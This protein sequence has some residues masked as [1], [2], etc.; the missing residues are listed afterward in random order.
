[1]KTIFFLSCILLSGIGFVYAQPITV[2]GKV[3]VSSGFAIPNVT[4]KA[5]QEKRVIYSDTAGEFNFNVSPYSTVLLSF[6]GYEE[7]EIKVFDKA[8]DTVIIM[9]PDNSKSGAVESMTQ[10]VNN[11]NFQAAI[12]T[13]VGNTTVYGSSINSSGGTFMPVFIHKEET[14]GSRYLFNDWMKGSVVTKADIVVNSTS[15]G[16]N[17]DKIKGTLLFTQDGQSA[18]SVEPADLKSFTL[19]DRDGHEQLFRIVPSIDN[20]L[21]VNVVS[22]GPYYNFYKLTQTKFIKSNYHSDGMTSTGNPYDEY[23]DDFYYFLEDAKE[24][25]S[26]C[27]WLTKKKKVTGFSPITVM[28]QW[29]RIMSGT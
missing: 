3:R 24:R 10:K 16:Y 9:R 23:T 7:T 20:K 13:G 8:I 25:H 27:C 18:V 11:D 12:S 22:E 15:Y 1:M 4:V 19:I 17:Y 6:E 29:T 2:K 14:Q 28:R 21:F 26:G 5:V